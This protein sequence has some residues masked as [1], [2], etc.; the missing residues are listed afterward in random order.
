MPD[1]IRGSADGGSSRQAGEGVPRDIQAEVAAADRNKS[2]REENGAMHAGA[3]HYPEPPFPK[4]HQPKP[5]SEARLDPQP[6][7]YAPFYLGSRK[8]EAKVALISGGDSGIG[9]AVAVLFARE[10]ATSRF[11]ILMNTPMPRSPEWR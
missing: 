2:K 5:G 10:G 9:R 11:L 7:Y 4:Q 1:G 8:L 6:M 3:R